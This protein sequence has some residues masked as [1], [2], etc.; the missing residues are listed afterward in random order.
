MK[1]GCITLKDDN[2]MPAKKILNSSKV[3]LFYIN[4]TILLIII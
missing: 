4:V 1:Y 3:V 2:I